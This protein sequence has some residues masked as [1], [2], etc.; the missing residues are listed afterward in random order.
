MCMSLT[1]LSHRSDTKFDMNLAQV[2]DRNPTYASQICD[3]QVTHHLNQN[4]GEA[5]SSS[6]PEK[7]LTKYMTK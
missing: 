7:Q 5:Q 2:L 3:I 6:D 4:N 1:L